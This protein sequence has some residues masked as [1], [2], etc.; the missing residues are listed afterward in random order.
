MCVG[1]K[2]EKEESCE[3]S[4]LSG[5]AGS[6]A[7]DHDTLWLTLSRGDNPQQIHKQTNKQLPNITKNVSRKQVIWLRCVQLYETVKPPFSIKFMPWDFEREHNFPL[8][9][10]SLNR[11]MKTS[12]ASTLWAPLRARNILLR[13]LPRYQL[14]YQASQLRHYT[15]EDIMNT[16]ESI[17]HKAADRTERRLLVNLYI[18][19]SDQIINSLFFNDLL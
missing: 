11:G 18:Y 16:N 19:A 1:Q 2:P 9:E 6:P 7:G 4:Q 12:W 15:L 8:I 17:I 14:L 5:R 3:C 10:L 13:S